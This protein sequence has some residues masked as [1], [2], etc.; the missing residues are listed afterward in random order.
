M[1]GWEVT[2]KIKFSAPGAKK[3]FEDLTKWAEKLETTLKGVTDAAAKIDESVVGLSETA[4]AAAASIADVNANLVKTKA[5]S[6][7]AVIATNRSTAGYAGMAGAANAASAA[8]LRL[9]GAQRLMLG[10]GAQ[11]ALGPGIGRGNFSSATA[12]T[13]GLGSAALMPRWYSPQYWN[14]ARPPIGGA[15]PPAG[16]TG[17]GMINVTPPGGNVPGSPGSGAGWWGY[18]YNVAR[19][20]GGGGAGGGPPGVPPISPGGGTPRGNWW[21]NLAGAGSGLGASMLGVGAAGAGFAGHIM[22]NVARRAIE[23]GILGAAGASADAMWDAARLQT[24]LTTTKNITASSPAQMANL[25]QLL[26]K[27]GDQTGMSVVQTGEMF[28]SMARQMQG[29]MKLS[30]MEQMLPYMARFQTVMGAARHFQPEQTTDA[31]MALTHLMRQ[32]DPKGMPVMFDQLLR[33]GELMPDDLKKAVTQMTY[34]EQTLKSMGVPDQDA[35]TA[36]IAMSR[37]GMGKNKGGTSLQ[38]LVQGAV[39]ALELTA[40][41]QQGKAGILKDMGLVD[42]HGKS[43]FFTQTRDPKTGKW[44][45]HGDLFGTGP[46]DLGFLGALE[47]YTERVG[48]II[49]GQAIESLFHKTG[50][51]VG[52]IFSDPVMIGQLQLLLDVIRH[53][54]SLGLKQQSDSIFGTAEFQGKRAWNDFQSV[55]TRIGMIALPGVTKGFRDLATSFNDARMWL[56]Q[57]KALTK[58]T[59]DWITNSVAGTERWLVSHHSDWEAFAHEL[60]DLGITAAQLAPQ[61]KTVGDGFIEVLKVVSDVLKILPIKPGDWQAKPGP[62]W[63]DSSTSTSNANTRT[64]A[65]NDH[66]PKTGIDLGNAF[67]TLKK[68]NDALW[69][70]ATGTT[71]TT[72]RADHRV[73]MREVTKPSQPQTSIHI[74]QVILQLPKGST[75]D[76]AKKLLAELANPMSILRSG[77]QS[78]SHPAISNALTIGPSGT[79]YT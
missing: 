24:I 55:M 72:H 22:Q 20:A 36:M 56:S 37:F 33:M 19:P 52:Q 29:S 3:L 75:G 25:E 70:W 32:Y 77:G 54:T 27:T 14:A 11:M 50:S 18:G 34:F 13:I 62:H 40:H 78:R 67:N 28:R 1:A 43:L 73:R 10:S 69:D 30:S 74:Q 58:A 5:A 61:M 45:A 57:H 79:P 8:I 41:A 15:L 48:P 4:K 35:M 53:Q 26:Y 39:P 31:V 60:K 16:S 23:G 12:R 17:G 42:A 9:A 2:S 49:A 76:D 59:S 71:A 38:N 44:Q 66:R 63:W 6:D 21:G 7:L 65:L 46:N 47:K 51:R 68:E 64:K